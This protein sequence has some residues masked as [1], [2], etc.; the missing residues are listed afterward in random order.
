M[1]VVSS[2]QAFLQ[3]FKMVGAAVP[4]DVAAACKGKSVYSLKNTIFYSML[5]TKRSAVLNM[6]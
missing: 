2:P 5:E 4:V 6:I 1:G 3:Q